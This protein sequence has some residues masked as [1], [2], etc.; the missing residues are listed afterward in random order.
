[1]LPVSL[2]LYK[3]DGENKAKMIRVQCVSSA[4]GR[5]S[6]QFGGPNPVTAC[7]VATK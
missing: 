3:I 4:I 2:R 7:A 1:M 5:S 6:L